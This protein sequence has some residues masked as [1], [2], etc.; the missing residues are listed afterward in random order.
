MDRLLGAL[1]APEECERGVV[2][3][4]DPSSL[5]ANISRFPS[6]VPPLVAV[7]DALVLISNIEDELFDIR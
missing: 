3:P 5:P 1:G 6:R 4:L 2:L 7:R